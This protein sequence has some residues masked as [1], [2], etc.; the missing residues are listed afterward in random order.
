LTPC[1]VRLD[2]YRDALGFVV[3]LYGRL[4][5]HYGTRGP[6]DSQ[7]GHRRPGA[8]STGKPRSC[9]AANPPATSNAPRRRVSFDRTACWHR[10]IAPGP[11][12]RSAW[13]ASETG[14]RARR[15]AVVAALDVS[16]QVEDPCLAALDE[17]PRL[18]RRDS[19]GH[20]HL[21]VLGQHER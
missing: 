21:R 19:V 8:L 11:S 3:K 17:L 13:R 15:R 10:Y 7:T 16:P 4:P 5:D 2:D 18:D 9:Q 20:C 6:D 14:L 1:V 12:G